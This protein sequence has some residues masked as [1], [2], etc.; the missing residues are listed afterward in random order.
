VIGTRS[1]AAGPPASIDEQKRDQ[2][3]PSVL[4]FLSSSRLIHTPAFGEEQEPDQSERGS[5]FQV[6]AVLSVDAED[7]RLSSFRSE[8]PVRINSAV[9]GGRSTGGRESVVSESAEAA[10]PECA[11]AIASKALDFT[12]SLV[13]VFGGIGAVAT[14]LVVYIAVQALGE[15]RQDE[16]HRARGARPEG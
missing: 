6:G 16:E 12:V 9:A 5:C 14:G 1:Q 15:R 11:M 10:R 7:T 13:A 4:V 8:S 2:R 3:R